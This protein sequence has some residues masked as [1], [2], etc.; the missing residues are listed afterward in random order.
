MVNAFGIGS[1]SGN[2]AGVCI[3]EQWPGTGEL[4]NMATQLNLPETA[5][6]IPVKK[7][8]WSI[9]WF[10]VKHEI[11]LC[12]H[13]TLAAAHCLFCRELNARIRFFLT[14]RVAN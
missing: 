11:F 5:F 1:Q 14:L 13:A 3:L 6:V 8:V 10:S 7:D 9:R 12:G 2:P 4:Q